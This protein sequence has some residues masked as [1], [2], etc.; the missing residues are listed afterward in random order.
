MD[1]GPEK[2]IPHFYADYDLIKE[3][4]KIFKIEKIYQLED[5]YEENDKKYT[6][7]H[8]HVLIVK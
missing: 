1:D 8:Y 6:S 4:F 7:F 5:F 2:G 3:L